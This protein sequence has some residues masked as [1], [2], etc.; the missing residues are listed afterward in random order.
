MISDNSSE[1]E[2][3]RAAN[4][5]IGAILKIIGRSPIV[6]DDVFDVLLT[7]ALKLCE[8]EFGILHL[9]EKDR[10]FRAVSTMGV[11]A[12]FEKWLVDEGDIKPHPDTALG[13]IEQ[14]KKPIII[15]DVKSEDI[16]EKGEPLRI[17]TA[18]LGGARTFIAFPMLAG[19]ELRA[20]RIQLDSIECGLL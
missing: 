4:E 19:D 2:M 18:D 16:Y 5:A 7:N 11:P 15:R 8:A 12:K 1:L 3:A 10:G 13:R 17:A 9:Y 6:L 14:Q 20:T